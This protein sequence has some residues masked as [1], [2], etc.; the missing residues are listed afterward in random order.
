MRQRAFRAVARA[1]LTPD[2]PPGA[3]AVVRIPEVR[4]NFAAERK[5]PLWS[6]ETESRIL[7]QLSQV[8]GLAAIDIE[9]DCRAT[10]CRI[11]IALPNEVPSL[12]QLVVATPDHGLILSVADRLGMETGLLLHNEYG[13]TFEAYIG[14]TKDSSPQSKA[15]SGETTG[16]A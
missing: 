14:R 5:D 11:E 1:P 10:Q 3:Q 7:D 6:A 12:E 15:K 2:K 13:N 4:K 8:P 9:V 16:N